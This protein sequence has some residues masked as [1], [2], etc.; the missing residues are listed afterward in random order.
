[1]SN[2]LWFLVQYSCPILCVFCVVHSFSNPYFIVYSS[3][4]TFPEQKS[5]PLFIVMTLFLKNVVKL[6]LISNAYFWLD[7]KVLW[8]CQYCIGYNSFN[9]SGRF[10]C[11][12]GSFLLFL[13][14]HC[15]TARITG[16][17][18]SKVGKQRQ[19]DKRWVWPW[20][21]SKRY[22]SEEVSGSSEWCAR[23]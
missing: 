20:T 19:M 23:R 21:E 2:I 5:E 13:L 4:I 14:H 11:R 16:K 12:P 10:W 1:M 18:E 7:N 3:H 8:I 9:N 6:G 22:N 15:N 17:R